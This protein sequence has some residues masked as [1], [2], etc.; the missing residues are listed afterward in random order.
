[1]ISI[2]VVVTLAL[3]NLAAGLEYP[4]LLANAAA[5]GALA[6]VAWREMR[7]QKEPGPAD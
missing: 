2:A 6:V 5:L 4:P 1:M 7:Q 3:V